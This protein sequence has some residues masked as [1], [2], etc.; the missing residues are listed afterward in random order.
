MHL[1]RHHAMPRVSTA[2]AALLLMSLTAT[3]SEAATICTVA[4][5]YAD[6]TDANCPDPPSLAT[7]NIAKNHNLLGSTSNCTLD[8]G[9]RDVVFNNSTLSLRSGKITVIAKSVS[10]N[11]STYF[12]GRGNNSGG[13]TN[14][15]SN[16]TIQATGGNISL[17]ASNSRI[18]V[19][20]NAQSGRI[21]LNASGAVSITGQLKS[22]LM[23]STGFSGS[24]DIIAGTTITAVSASTIDISGRAYDPAVIPVPVV[25]PK[26]KL[27]A[28]G[29]ISLATNTG[30]NL[31]GGGPP[32][33]GLVVATSGDFLT[34]N[35]N[36]TIDVG[37]NSASIDCN[38]FT[39][40]AGV[41]L[42][43]RG[44]NAAPA[45][46]GAVVTINALG[47]VSVPLVSGSTARILAGG[48]LL[49]GRVVID[50][51]SSVA[52][53]GMINVDGLSTGADSGTLTINA[54][55]SITT[56]TGST[57][58]GFGQSGR[59]G[60]EFTFSA[61]TDISLATTVNLNGGDGGA[62]ELSAGGNISMAGF[63]AE[64]NGTGQVQDLGSGGILCADAGSN[65]TFNSAITARGTHDGCGGCVSGFA[66][67]GN[68]LIKGN[69][70]VDSHLPWEG[71]AGGGITM[72]AAGT[73]ITET[74]ATLSA[75]GNGAYGCGGSICIDGNLG[76]TLNGE[77][78]ASG[79]SGGFIDIFSDSSITIA[80][81][82]RAQADSYGSPGGELNVTAGVDGQGNLTVGALITVQGGSCSAEEG[83]GTGGSANL[84][85][86]TVNMTAASSI[87]A[88]APDGA[89]D[90]RITAHEGL[91]VAG[92]INA[93]KT[94]TFGV[95]GTVAFDYRSTITPSVTGSIQP[96]ATHVTHPTCV[97]PLDPVECL[98][99]CPT[100]GNGTIEYPET[101]DSGTQPPLSCVTISGDLTCSRFCRQES[102]DDNNV[103]TDETCDPVY[104][105][106]NSPAAFCPT[107]TP[108]FTH[109]GPS[110]TPTPTRTPTNTRTGT[111]TRTPTITMT[112]TI[113]AT[114]TISGTPTR[115]PTVSN[116]P[117]VTP[118]P[119]ITPP[120]LRV[121]TMVVARPGGRMCIPAQLFNAGSPLG[122]M[123]DI[124]DLSS[125]PMTFNSVGINPNIGPMTAVDK[126]VS[127]TTN[128]AFDTYEV[129]GTNM[130]GI[131]NGDLYTA[132]YT[133]S[134]QATP[135][136]YGISEPVPG[137]TIRISTCTGDCNG[138]NQVSIGEVQQCVNKF[139][140]ASLCTLSASV[141][142]CPIADANNNGEVSIGE[143]QQCVSRF[144][145]GCP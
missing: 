137:A 125:L 118:T 70:T 59:V 103:C 122:T 111:T 55:T 13:S 10:I 138:N 4:D 62:L 117:T 120:A 63:T 136:L 121:H 76:I 33:E 16:V 43:A 22:E 40:T 53:G 23:Q 60:G 124:G 14:N 102:C 145:G 141:S 82:L 52:I 9:N 46:I 25:P 79:G 112:P 135:G 105:C 68:I 78:T 24:V 32:I 74:A 73:V 26:L 58:S 127:R 97:G 17:G 69:I 71:G 126:D 83:C 92:S 50:A 42:D 87:D 131:P 7:C 48:N 20:A 140:G 64:G 93:L 114:P 39:M 34:P 133:V 61:G 66:N 72:L 80:K 49:G 67:F 123:N 44:N 5:I 35:T 41:T 8:F 104:G 96:A 11:G 21:V 45:N 142:N 27:T 31:D 129:S 30:V 89:G 38:N 2:F 119:T 54:G 99:R 108:T 75:Y 6:E 12:D 56:T 139:L 132:Q 109:T 143:V 107:A 1:I 115:T 84:E 15:G 94:G 77:T 95:N 113:S 47:A 88:R 91:T 81:P 85:G 86:C 29:N 98:T 3:T 101:C 51:G 19:G 134:A 144:L 28:T 18:H 106:R 57:L 100:C 110:V 130:V 90:V 37:A 65:L 128:G 116:T 36:M